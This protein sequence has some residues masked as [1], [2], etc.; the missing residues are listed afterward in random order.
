MPTGYFGEGKTFSKKL[1]KWIKTEK[2]KAFDYES[3]EDEQKKSA[4]LLISFFRY[5]PDLFYDVI[6]SPSAKYKL[7]LP[8]RLMLRVWARYRNTY[9]TGG[10][11]LTK[12]FTLQLAK[13]HDGIFFPGEK[14]R[15]VAPSQK[16]SAKLASDAFKTV[17][18]NYPLMASWW[19]INAERSDMFR[20]T[21][22]YG[23]EF[24]MYAPRGDNCSAIVGEEIAAEG[25]DGFDIENFESDISPTCRLTR[26]IRGVDDRCHINLK[27]SYISNASSR[28][29]KAYTTYRKNALKD[30]IHGDKYDG[31][32]MDISWISALLCNLRDISYY[33][34][35]RKK[36]TA[37]NWAREMDVRY[38]GT[39]DRPM[40]TDEILARS[41]RLMVM[42]DRHC[43]KTEPIYI[44][45][46]DVSY[47]DDKKNAKCADIVVKLTPYKEQ[48]KRDKYRKQVVYADNY[49]PPKTAY[50]QAQ[51]LKDLW[52]RFCCNGAQTTYLVV[53]TW[54]YGTEVVEELMKPTSDGSEPLCCI[55][56]MAFT[57]IE[58]PDALPVIYP[59]KAGTRGTND[60]DG[61]MIKYAQIEFEQGN[62]ELLTA[63]VLDGI[64]AYKNSHGI[65]DNTADGNIAMPYKQTDLLCQQ[66]SNLR[67]KVSGVTLK[68]E[69]I[70]KAIQRDLW[71][72]L[73]YALR[74]AQL[75]EADLKKDKYKPKS[76]WESV[77]E[78]FSKGSQ[79]VSQSN[80]V[81]NTR[82]NLLSLRRR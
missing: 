3:L 76:D 26:K 30:M 15:Y 66:I 65:K 29:N 10:R 48:Y 69:R 33:K 54:Q 32:C 50:L 35:E 38:T 8:Q 51:R 47:V 40:I 44:V 43:G 72:A 70:S 5:Y 64:E 73:K 11:G 20:I 18:E 1:G 68:E 6:R 41:K 80:R 61:E 62:V 14:I 67:T 57:E 34:K 31:F 59:M 24:T 2:E 60:A 21:T 55:N 12:T 42:E 23:S 56:H 13:D 74:M 71:S 46:H 53:D 58:Q 75:L 81:S 63:N 19:N 22:P 79:A 27:E 45:S 7:E 25:E 16:Q 82:A 17:S 9:I 39:G 36:L 78:G 37:E 77:I 52:R 28:Q 49:P 4:A